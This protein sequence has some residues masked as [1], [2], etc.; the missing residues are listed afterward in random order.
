MQ[1]RFNYQ[2]VQTLSR[3]QFRQQGQRGRLQAA[4]FGGEGG[5]R[6][7]N[8]QLCREIV[9]TAGEQGFVNLMTEPAFAE[10]PKILETPKDEEGRWDREG[11]AALRKLARRKG[12]A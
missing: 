3:H 10:V 12:S 2:P 5:Y 11:L 1:L 4:V 9:V 6:I 8:E 7:N